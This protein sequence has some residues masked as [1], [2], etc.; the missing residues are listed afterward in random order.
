L[1]NGNKKEMR[2]RGSEKLSP[3][4]PLYAQELDK[5]GGIAAMLDSRC[6]M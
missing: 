6:L 5:K 1:K 4:P 3:A 2:R